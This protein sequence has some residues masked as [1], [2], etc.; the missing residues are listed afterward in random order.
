[1]KESLI[2]AKVMDYGKLK[3]I[4]KEIL[5]Y[6]LYVDALKKKGI[7]EKVDPPPTLPKSIV[8]SVLTGGIP[9]DGPLQIEL[10]SNDVVKIKEYNTLVK[11]QSDSRLPL[12][13]IVEY[14]D[15]DIRVYLAYRE[16]P[17]I[18]GLDLGLR[19]LITIVAIKDT[20]PWKVRFF[21]EPKLMEKFANFLSENQGIIK[22]EEMKSNAKRIIYEAVS[23]IEDLEPKVVAMENLEYFETKTGKGLRALQNML[24]NEIRRRGIRYRKIDPYNTSRVCAKCGYKKGEILGSL[25]VCPACGYKADRDYNAAY[26][27]A[28]KCYYTC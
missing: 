11:I 22:L 25:F 21:D 20:K 3:D 12:Y 10:V 14:R 5:Y 6:K 8:S 15:T 2:E 18:V 19:H 1:M 9:R 28:L 16:N 26:N 24:E 7:K 17:S 23:F 4:Q 13:A 27:I